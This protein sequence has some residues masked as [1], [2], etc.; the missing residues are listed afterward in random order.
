M[1]V[2]LTDYQQKVEENADLARM[3]D[4]FRRMIP[5]G[6]PTESEGRFI[7]TAGVNAKGWEFVTLLSFA[8]ANAT[9]FTEDNDPYGDHSF[10]SVTIGGE[11]VWWKIDYYDVA[12]TNGSE[13][14][15]DPSQTRRV[16]TAL[17]P[18]EY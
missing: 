13:N 12:L 9:T 7:V 4:R 2:A 3:N 16:L 8:I 17:F 6:G 10:G 15:R 18:S 5:F 14:P 1:A 11:V